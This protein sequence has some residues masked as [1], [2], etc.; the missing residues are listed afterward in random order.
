MFIFIKD[1][2]ASKTGVYFINEKTGLELSFYKI[3]QIELESF[4]SESSVPSTQT[5][6]FC[7][8]GA[9]SPFSVVKKARTGLLFIHKVG[10]SHP[11]KYVGISSLARLRSLFPSMK[12]HTLGTGCCL[13]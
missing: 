3:L 2:E 1:C 7:V 10:K 8:G 13:D 12:P 6:Y 4:G 11:W 9:S 5:P